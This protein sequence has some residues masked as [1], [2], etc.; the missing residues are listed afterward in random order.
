M[1]DDWIF[2][3]E[4]KQR[5][6]HSSEGHLSQMELKSVPFTSTTFWHVSW[7]PD[8]SSRPTTRWHVESI[9]MK[10]RKFRRFLNNINTYVYMM[11]SEREVG[12]ENFW[13]IMAMDCFVAWLQPKFFNKCDRNIFRYGVPGVG[14]SPSSGHPFFGAGRNFKFLPEIFSAYQ[15]V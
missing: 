5:R 2:G 12:L 9:R 14:N 13:D 4:S 8:A 1:C 3:S 6:R 10:D 15:T 7:L 11:D